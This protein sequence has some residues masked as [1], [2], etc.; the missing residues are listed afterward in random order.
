MRNEQWMTTTTAILLHSYIIY[1]LI[2]KFNPSTIEIKSKDVYPVFPLYFF[3]PKQETSEINRFTSIKKLRIEKF[4]ISTPNYHLN[5][6]IYVN[7]SPALL[8]TAHLSN[9]RDISSVT[10]KGL[11]IFK[12]KSNFLY[13]YT[14]R[15]YENP[16]QILFQFI[17][18]AVRQRNCAD[19]KKYRFETVNLLLFIFARG[20]IRDERHGIFPP[21]FAVIDAFRQ[22]WKFSPALKTRSP[23]LQVR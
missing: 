8:S 9:V 2:R 5:L 22:L 11:I 20:G 17:L 18:D 16:R 12:T 13:I 10:T 3:S 19:R 21:S 7:I 15:L 1:F 14:T 4:S 6:K 23:K